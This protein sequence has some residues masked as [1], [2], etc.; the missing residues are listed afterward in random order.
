LSVQKWTS[1]VKVTYKDEEVCDK[2][3]AVI[4]G[5]FHKYIPIFLINFLSSLDVAS[6]PRRNSASISPSLPIVQV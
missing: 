3:S 5:T 6:P 2:V 4:L 1:L